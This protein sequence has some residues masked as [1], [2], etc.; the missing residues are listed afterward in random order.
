M[1]ERI[2]RIEKP[3]GGD[4][5]VVEAFKMFPLR[6]AEGKTSRTIVNSMVNYSLKAGANSLIATEQAD[7][8][9]L[10]PVPHNGVSVKQRI[11]GGFRQTYL[12]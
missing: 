4:M 8:Q 11:R 3:N 7:I 10:A 6:N 1:L 12:Y 5:T 9:R 2:G